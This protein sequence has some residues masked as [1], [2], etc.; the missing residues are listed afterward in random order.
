MAVLLIAATPFKLEEL[1]DFVIRKSRSIRL[2]DSG[3]QTCKLGDIGT[4]DVNAC[5]VEKFPVI[6]KGLQGVDGDFKMSVLRF[7]THVRMIH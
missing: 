7:I 4:T 5:A 1:C 3:K 6:P 2:S